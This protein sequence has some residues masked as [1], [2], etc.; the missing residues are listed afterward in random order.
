[1]RNPRRYGT[2]YST[3]VLRLYGD[4]VHAIKKKLISPKPAGSESE[5]VTQGC[6]LEATNRVGTIANSPDLKMGRLL[7]CGLWNDPVTLTQDVVRQDQE[8]PSGS[9]GQMMNHTYGHHGAWKMCLNCRARNP[10]QT[11][12]QA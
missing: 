6:Q 9:C 7:T 3:A 8:P 10:Q 1:M 2:V 12:N 4:T 11:Q 5:P